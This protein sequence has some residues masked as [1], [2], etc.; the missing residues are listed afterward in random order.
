MYEPKDHVSIRITEKLQELPDSSYKPSIFRV[1]DD[2]RCVDEKLYEPKLLAVGPFHH[3]KKHLQKM[4]QHKFRYLRHL[5]KRIDKYSV[6]DYVMEIRS[7]EEKAR[8]CYADSIEL[9]RDNFVHMLLLDGIFII[10]LIRKYLFYEWREDDDT[11][12][13]HEQVLIQLFHDLMLVENQVPF[14]VLE[15]LFS[16]T[17]SD[18]DDNILYLIQAFADYISPWPDASKITGEVSMENIDHLLGLV[19]RIWCSSFAETSRPDKAE[20]DRNWCSFAKMVASTPVKAEEEEVLAINSS[21][22][23]QEA[24]IKFLKDTESNF[25]DIKFTKGVMK[26]PRFHVKDATESVLRNLIAYEHFVIVRHPKYVTYYAFFWDCLINS[27]KDVVILR[28]HGIFTNWLGDDEMVCSMFNRL[29]RDKLKPPDF[30]YDDVFN[31][32]NQHCRNP[33]HSWMANLRHNYFNTPWAFISFFAAL[34]LLLFTLTQ[35]VFSVLSYT[36]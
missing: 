4:E 24:G 16:M 31:K 30:C 34:M 29:G 2:L 1:S 12:F 7:L 14:F 36:M 6:D 28:R 21:T 15:K 10:E 22:E 32:V 18:P 8:G 23:L 27:S 17:E 11:I 20:E 5:L 13:Q 9:S 26:I 35:T 25:L 3:G 19:Y 33:W